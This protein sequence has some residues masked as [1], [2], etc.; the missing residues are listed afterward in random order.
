M[1]K[2]ARLISVKL[3]KNDLSAEHYHSFYSHDLKL[4]EIIK[5]TLAF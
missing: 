5:E 3:I 2:I 4:T 1:A